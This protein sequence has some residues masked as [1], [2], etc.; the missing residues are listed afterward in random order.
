MAFAA[1]PARTQNL[2]AL[3][4]NCTNLHPKVAH[5]GRS[6]RILEIPQ[7][8][9]RYQTVHGIRSIPKI[10]PSMQFVVVH[11]PPF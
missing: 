11:I 7:L 1:V 2:L 6:P 5:L 10:L 3:H 9:C 8:S 4:S